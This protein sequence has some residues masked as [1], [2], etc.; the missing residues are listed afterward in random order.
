M[1]GPDSTTQAAAAGGALLAPLSTDLG[2]V[3]FLPHLD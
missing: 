2:E 3:W 1:I